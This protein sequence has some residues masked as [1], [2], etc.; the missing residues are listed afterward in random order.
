MEDVL[1]IDDPSRTHIKVNP[2]SE[3]FL[4]KQGYVKFDDIIAPQVTI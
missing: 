1:H 2:G 3:E 4:G